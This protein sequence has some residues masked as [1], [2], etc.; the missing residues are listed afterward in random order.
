MSALGTSQSSTSD[1]PSKTFHVKKPPSNSSHDIRDAILRDEFGFSAVEIAALTKSDDRLF[2][3]SENNGPTWATTNQVRAWPTNPNGEV[4]ISVT[5]TAVK[6]ILAFHER[7]LKSKINE[8]L[9]F[10]TDPQLRS[11]V[12][13]DLL[14]ILNS[15]DNERIGSMYDL[16]NDT[17]GS[18]QSAAE[19]SRAV[20]YLTDKAGYANNPF[21]ALIKANSALTDYRMKSG[22]GYDSVALLLL[23]DAT[24]TATANYMF[25]SGKNS[26]TVSRM[27]AAVINRQL[28]TMYSQA[29][30]EG[31]F[32]RREWAARLY[33]V[34][35]EERAGFREGDLIELISPGTSMRAPRPTTNAE[36]QLRKLDRERRET[37]RIQEETDQIGSQVVPTDQRTSEYYQSSEDGHYY[38]D[39]ERRKIRG[40][41]KG[42]QPKFKVVMRYDN[43][44]QRANVWADGYGAALELPVKAVKYA[45]TLRRLNELTVYLHKRD[46]LLSEINNQNRYMVPPK[47]EK[48]KSM[49]QQV[50]KY[51]RILSSPLDKTR[52]QGT[53]VQLEQ[54]LEDSYAAWGRPK[55]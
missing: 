33:D 21:L 51:G 12:M 32:L 49:I 40:T 20:T 50:Q 52:I 31:E 3:I 6:A 2:Y 47:P 30:K 7:F 36:E 54:L 1:E 37:V 9:A 11:E 43:P 17:T 15:S 45:V 41:K 48:V 53:L 42:Y 23:N 25:G 19:I 27:E 13:K 38:E 44:Y 4:S 46:K 29:G 24:R 16:I 5:E 26:S 34:S 14:S 18:L 10:I 39:L 55:Q 35:D 22:P 28:A 8:A